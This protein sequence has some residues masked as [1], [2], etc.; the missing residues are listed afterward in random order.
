MISTSVWSSLKTLT[1][2]PRDC[3]S[4]RS[5]LKDSGIPGSGMLSPLMIAS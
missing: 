3:S 2:R 1:S 4:F 5:T